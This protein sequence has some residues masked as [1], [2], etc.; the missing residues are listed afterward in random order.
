MA[1]NGLFLWGEL[2]A[3]IDIDHLLSDAFDQGIL[4]IKGS[5]FSPTGSYVNYIRFN[6]AYATE[7]QLS[8][9]LRKA[10]QS[11]K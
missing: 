10:I 2:P 7:P 8:T 6:A 4:F 11:D 5:L 1:T 3:H 9:F